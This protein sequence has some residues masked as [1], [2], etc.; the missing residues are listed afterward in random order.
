MASS[1]GYY[2]LIGMQY[3]GGL[4]TIKVAKFR[5]KMSEIFM[6]M[7]SNNYCMQKLDG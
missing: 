4:A 7:L 3:R 1:I 2:R 6:I 5:H